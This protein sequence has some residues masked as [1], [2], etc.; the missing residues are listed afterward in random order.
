[1]KVH[2]TLTLLIILIFPTGSFSQFQF[3]I[4]FIGGAPTGE[5]DEINNFGAGIYLE[6]IFGVNAKT[7][8]GLEGSAIYFAEVDPGSTSSTDPTVMVPI[9]ITGVYDFWDAK[10]TPYAGVGVGPYI[11]D[12]EF[13]NKTKVGVNPR[14]GVYFGSLNLGVG[15]HIVKDFNFFSFQIGYLKRKFK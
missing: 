11:I 2:I 4:G 13:T 14:V 7:N 3:G 5:F 9:L 12:N 8:I 10:W 1:M 15:Y 6:G